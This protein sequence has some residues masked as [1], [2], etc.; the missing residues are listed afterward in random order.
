MPRAPSLRISEVCTRIETDL[1]A[2]WRTATLAGMA[3]M[4]QHHFQRQFAAVTG[5]TVAGYIR[6]RRM[7]RAALLLRDTQQRVIDIALES[8]FQTHAAL[9]RAFSSHFGTSPRQFRA[10]GRLS[11]CSDLPARP[12]LLSQRSRNFCAHWDEVPISDCWLCA[13]ET[14][15]VR[16]GRFFEDPAQIHREFGDLRAELGGR[17]SMISTAVCKAPTGFRD[18]NAK[19]YYGAILP[20]RV[21]LTWPSD[22]KRLDAGLYAVF[23]HYG[24]LAA[25]FLTWNRCVRAGFD[26]VGAKFR[27]GWMF[28]TY[29]SKTPDAPPDELSA[30][31]YFPIAKSTVRKTVEPARQIQ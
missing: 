30:L 17:P 1:A 8:G 25:L 7:E 14:Q 31:I 26:Q 27:P 9:T 28:E 13:R 16:D 21:G 11:R 3:G 6:A 12:Y 22:W 15:G 4:A 19:A 24:P 18:L 23:P 10:T 5:E 2:P 29:L 20:E